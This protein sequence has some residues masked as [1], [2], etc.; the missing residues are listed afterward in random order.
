[1]KKKTLVIIL[2]AVIVIAS[3]S[4]FFYPK[5][6]VVG[7]LRGFIGPNETAYREEYSCFGIKH[8]FC[9]PWPDYGCDLLCY[10]LIFDKKCYTETVQGGSKLI[11]TPTTCR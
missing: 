3:L 1:M 2:I 9:P 11:K 6:R 8:D 10:G 4:V 7:G 5:K